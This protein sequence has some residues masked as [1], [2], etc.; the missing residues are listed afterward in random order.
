MADCPKCHYVRTEA[1]S[2][3]PEGVCPAC[4]I[5][6]AKWLAA[7][8][9]TAATTTTRTEDAEE[10]LLEQPDNPDILTEKFRFWLLYIPDQVDPLVFWGRVTAYLLFFVWGWWF[11]FTNGSWQDIGG[12]FLHSINLPFHEFGH[13]LFRP[14]GH[15][16]MILGGSLFQVLLP[17]VVLV[18]FVK[19]GD[20]Y[21]ASVMLWWC[22]QNF[23]DI[24]PYIADAEYRGL[25]L[26]MGMGE[27]FHDWGNLL[28]MMGMVDKAYHLGRASFLL[29]SA[30]ILLSFA[31]GGYVLYKQK[32]NINP[33]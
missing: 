16:M 14:F 5:A 31:W 17:L 6:Y 1:D 18:F 19:Q 29:G 10:G 9:N 13:V 26:I 8:Q 33:W 7:Q 23:I 21:E 27:D 30:I 3:V 28:S 22:G 12:S 4:G 24:S 20:T 11:I 25:P 2:H 15:F 32:Q